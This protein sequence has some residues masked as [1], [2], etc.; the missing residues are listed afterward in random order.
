[1]G[2]FTATSIHTRLLIASLLIL[3][4][5]LGVTAMVLDRAFANYQL[6]SQQE[7]M[8]LQQL[9]LARA[10]DWDGQQW[11][12]QGLDDP[13]YQAPRSGLYGL[14]MSPAGELLWRSPSAELI[15][16]APESATA[17]AAAIAPLL[18]VAIG[19]TRFGECQL[20][21]LYYCHATGV[22]WGS[23]GPQSVF[24]I[25]ESRQPE[26]AAR[27]SYRQYLLW[28]SLATATLL[29]VAQTLVFRWG[30]SP[31]RGLARAIAALERGDADKLD[32]NY[33]AELAPLT[34]NLNL[35]LASETRRRERV[36]NTMDRLTHV[37]KSPLMLIRNSRDQGEEFRQL[38]DEQVTRMLGIVEGELARAR[39]DGRSA[40]IL[41]KPVPVR[42]V[43]ERIAA[44]Y[45]RLPRRNADPVLQGP[46]TIDLDQVAGTALFY[47]EERDLQDLF[48]TIL[49]NS[50]KYCRH[51]ISV[52]ADLVDDAEGGLLELSVADDGDGIAVGQEQA[53]LRRGARADSANAGQG[54]GLSIVVEIVSAYGG[55][56]HS[57]RS[58]LGGAMFVVRLPL[59]PGSG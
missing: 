14:V 40:H 55:S 17:I 9:L 25:I 49:E 39:L 12:F 19:E 28:L 36:R 43:L 42:P 7:S 10:A 57:R 18:A 5:F 33:P 53:I 50:L 26:M 44:A 16:G 48:G 27:R 51:H 4:L 15:P 38:V 34:T 41:G 3:P 56:L 21:P 8:R 24:L 45:S 20:G 29:L 47:G 31:L 30:L 46:V 1:V 37:L 52:A 2:V 23:Q 13:R 35:L 6:Q 54:L 11:Q 58:P 59:K 32:D 22:A